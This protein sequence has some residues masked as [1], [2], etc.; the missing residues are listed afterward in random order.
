MKTRL[1][2]A[3][4]AA[5]L[6]FGC[7]SA[8]KKQCEQT[9]WFN[10]GRQLAIDGKRIG[11]DD[12]IGSCQREEVE[13]DSSALDRGWKAGRGEYC[14]PQGAYLTGK[15]GDFLNSDLCEPNQIRKMLPEH[16]RGVEDYCHPQNGK[17][18]GSSGRLYNSVCPKNLEGAFLPE[19]NKGRQ[20]FLDAEI[21]KK[22]N[23]IR[24][25]DRKISDLQVQKRDYQNSLKDM[26]LRQTIGV[27]LDRERTD[28]ER[29]DQDQSRRQIEWNVQDTDRKIRQ[30]RD[31]QQKFENEIQTLEREKRALQ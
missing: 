13:V 9:N 18:A 3:V 14:E 8:L 28:K 26:Q 25:L 10:H 12:F 17:I 11:Q 19:F 29:M 23:E 22:R 30:H 21:S 27:A 24:T 2:G 15:R 1:I 5:T 31:T 20:I 4:G 7:T 6:L 16:A